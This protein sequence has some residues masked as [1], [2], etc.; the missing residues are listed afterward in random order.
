MQTFSKCSGKLII[1]SEKYQ[2]AIDI[3]EGMEANEMKTESTLYFIAMS[4]K[5]LKNYSKSVEYLNKN[6]KGNQF[7]QTQPGIMH[8]SGMCWKKSQL[9]RKVARSLSEKASFFE[10]KPLTLYTIATI[11]DQ[12]TENSLK[13]A[14][15][16]YK[17]YIYSKTSC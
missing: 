3:L 8:R 11:Y 12:K 7:R 4:Y 15:S 9:T 13:T 16:Y 14:L 5:A 10:N 17:R 2:P 6:D 1:Q